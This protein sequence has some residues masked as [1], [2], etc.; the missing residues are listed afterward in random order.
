[1]WKSGNVT[2]NTTVPEEVYGFKI[3]LI[4]HEELEPGTIKVLRNLPG[5]FPFISSHHTVN[6]RPADWL[7]TGQY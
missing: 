1:M 4:N 2:F 5:V 3:M 7:C 6:K